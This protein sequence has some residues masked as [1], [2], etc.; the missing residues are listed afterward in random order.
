MRKATKEDILIH[1]KLNFM[2]IYFNIFI[3]V[4]YNIKPNRIYN[5]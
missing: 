2:L 3:T 5:H 4:I 1:L